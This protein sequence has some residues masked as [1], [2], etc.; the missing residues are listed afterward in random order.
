MSAIVIQIAFVF[1]LN[2]AGTEP[3]GQSVMTRSDE[4]ISPV[5]IP[6]D[7]PPFEAVPVCA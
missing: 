1:R 5:P 2:A 7:V 6:S 3:K 4:R